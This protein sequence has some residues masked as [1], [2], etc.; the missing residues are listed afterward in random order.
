MK[1][2]KGLRILLLRYV[3]DTIRFHRMKIHE[4]CQF[5]NVPQPPIQI[6]L[7]FC[8]FG[9]SEYRDINKATRSRVL[10]RSHQVSRQNNGIH[11]ALFNSK[12]ERVFYTINN[13][14]L[15]FGVDKVSNSRPGRRART[16]MAHFSGWF[17]K[18]ATCFRCPGF[19][20]PN[21]EGP[22]QQRRQEMLLFPS[23]MAVVWF[24]WEWVQARPPRWR[25]RNKIEPKRSEALDIFKKKMVRSQACPNIGKMAHGLETSHIEL[26]RGR[27]RMLIV[28]KLRLDIVKKKG[29]N[30]AFTSTERKIKHLI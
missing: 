3:S 28:L 8:T 7:H 23:D 6:G 10:V 4:Q 20:S 12:F 14:T 22:S 26:L 5:R 17:T 16:G 1:R 30:W 25:P 19:L 24:D 11:K 9:L 13:S 15:Y 29:S 18:Y 2:D 21:F 27:R